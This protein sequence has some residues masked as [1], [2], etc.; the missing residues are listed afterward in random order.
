MLRSAASKV[1]WVGRAT[2]FLVGLA[3]IL[4]LTVGVVS[5]ATAHTGSA[6]LFHLGHNNPVRAVSTLAGGVAKG[7]LNV[8]NTS[9]ATTATAVGAANKSAV[10]PAVRATNSGGGPAL[11]LSVGAGKAPM[12]VSGGAAKVTNLDADTV[13]GKDSTE[14]AAATNGK[15]NNADLLDNKDSSEFLG[16][17]EK[18]ADADK[19]DGKDSSE[20]APRGYAQVATHRS[21]FLE[22]GRSK[23]VIGIQRTTPVGSTVESVYCFDLTFT[24]HTAVASPFLNNNA[25]VGTVTP[26]NS[27]LNSI[28]TAPYND[29]AARTFAANTS[30]DLSDINFGIT[31]M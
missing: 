17:T 6:G 29:A 30:A 10:S 2:V 26:P 4:A 16:K 25:V 3:V 28:C 31:F 13:D 9:T 11:G 8:S 19:L 21:D 7:V 12:T 1:M 24:P 20:L 15:A 22:P 27:L 18:A 23:G 5:R 14:F